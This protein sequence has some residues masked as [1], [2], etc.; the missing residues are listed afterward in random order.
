[1]IKYNKSKIYTLE[2]NFSSMTFKF[3]SLKKLE[4][5]YFDENIDIS[6]IYFINNKIKLKI[7]NITYEENRVL[8]Y[9]ENE[10]NIKYPLY[11]NTNN[12]NIDVP[13]YSLYTTEDFNKKY[14]YP[15]DLGVHY[16][17]TYS[18]F[19]F[20]SPSALKVSLKIYKETSDNIPIIL[21]SN[22][23]EENNNI[24]Y[25]KYYGDLK[26]YLYTYEVTHADC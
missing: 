5:S 1:M 23:L 7:I 22:E 3:Y 15:G 16:E 14:Y 11:L 4:I 8:I 20:W 25:I 18:E 21:S 19:T 12:I 10:I 17:T 13:Y 2:V 26:G 9:F 6:N 24:W